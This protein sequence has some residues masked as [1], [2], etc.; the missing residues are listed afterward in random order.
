MDLNSF[1]ELYAKGIILLEGKRNVPEKDK[2]KL[3]EIGKLLAE[4]MPHAT[5]RSGNADGS[6]YFFSQGVAC[7]SPKQLQVITP[8]V[9]HRKKYNLAETIFDLDSIDLLNEPDI[10]Y[11]SKNHKGTK[12][13]VEKYVAGDKDKY[14]I[15]AAY[16]LRDTIKVIGTQAGIPPISVGLF[17][18]DLNN[19]MQGGTG[20]TQRVCINNAIPLFTQETYFNWL[21]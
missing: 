14:A 10:V 1:C 16:I 21:E 11:H 3:I 4:K 15:K 13:L 20:H 8:Y 7:V 6:D 19:P 18:E 17:Y 5:F 2:I 12:S 9:N